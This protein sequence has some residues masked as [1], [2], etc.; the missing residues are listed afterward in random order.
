VLTLSQLATS[1]EYIQLQVVATQLN[2]AAYNP[3]SDP[4]YIAFVPITSPPSSP[5]P[6]SGEY[7]T[8]FW[9]TDTSG[10]FWAGIL[11][12]PLNGG[13]SLAAGSYLVCV[14]VTDDPAV[15]VKTGAY[16]TVV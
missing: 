4:V 15:P 12:G 14:K 1:T 11:V 5:D 2:G 7:N 3:S 10:L 9:T 8:A 16:L 13:V 6:T